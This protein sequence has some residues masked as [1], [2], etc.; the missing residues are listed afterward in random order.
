VTAPK[1]MCATC[2]EFF[3]PWGLKNHQKRCGVTCSIE[4]CDS[5]L[6]SLGMCSAHYQRFYK[7]GD[8]HYITPKKPPPN[9]GKTLPKKP[10]AVED[11][12][13]VARS[14]GWCSRHYACW[15]RTGDPIARIA[16]RRPGE[17]CQAEGCERPHRARGYCHPHYM[18]FVWNPSNPEALRAMARRR[19]ARRIG[20]L[21][22]P[23]SKDQ[24]VQRLSMWP[25]CWICGAPDPDTVDHVKPLAAGGADCLSNLRPA[26]R[27]CNAKKRD[28]WPLEV[29]G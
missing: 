7:F 12:D 20:N 17:V 21:A 9:K 2:G 1:E 3:V 14:R 5:P 29:A 19:K 26:C 24:L 10:C 11:C 25:G 13:E 22:I 28:T 18:R 6:K 27:S 4:G 15:V 8:P 16:P 23:F